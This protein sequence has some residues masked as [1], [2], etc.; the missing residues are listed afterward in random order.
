MVGRLIEQQNVGIAEQ[1]LREQHA[2]LL[3][4]VQLLHL[5][6]VQLGSGCR[7]RSAARPRPLSASQ[8]LKSANSAFELGRAHAVFVGEVR[9]GVERFLLLHDL[10]ELLMPHD[11]RLQHRTSSI[12]KVVLLAAP[13]SARPGVTWTIA[14]FGSILAG[15]NLQKGRFA[16]AVGADQAVAVARG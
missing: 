10:V 11:D 4:A 14:L 7:A 13:R 15:Q 8:P 9:L 3:V 1:R 16:G 5:L 6:V 2:H 12:G